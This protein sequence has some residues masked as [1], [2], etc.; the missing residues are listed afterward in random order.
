[1]AT[2]KGSDIIQDEHLANAIKQAQELKKAYDE[3][4]ASVVKANKDLSAQV[5]GNRGGSAKQ[6]QELNTALQES[7]KIKNAATKVDNDRIRLE[8]QLI[9]LQSEEIKQNE[10]LKVKIAEQRKENKLLAKETAGL[11]NAYTKLVSDTDKAQANFKKLAAQFGVNSSQ[12]KKAKADFERLDNEL[13]EINGSARDGRRD[14]GRY[15]IALQGA[16]GGAKKLLGALGVVGGVQLFSRVIKDAFNVV[17][18][19]DQSQANLA[20]VLGV[21]RESMGSLTEQAKALG[22]TTK[23]TASNVAEL[24]LEFAKLGFVQS[25][26]EGMTES[27]LQLAAAAGTDLG[28]AAAITGAT[29]RGFGLETSETQR[30][31]DVM[32]KSFSSSSLDITKFASAMSAVAPVANAAG[33]NIERTTALLGTLTDRGIDAS[34]AGT[35]LRNMFLSSTAA[36]ISF[37][38]ALAKVR[39]ASDKT[40]ESLKLFGKKGATLGVILA[41]NGDSVDSLEEKLN[42]AGGA[43]G[44]MADKQI[45]TL[46]GALDILRSSWEGAI[47]EMNEASGASDGLKDLILILAESIP[48]LVRGVSGLAGN[49]ASLIK[50]IVTLKST[51]EGAFDSQQS[52]ANAVADTVDSLLAEVPFISELTDLL[53]DNK[54]AL[55]PLT[56]EQKRNNYVKEQSLRVGREILQQNKEEISDVSVLIDAL[57][58]ENTTRQE[59]DEIITKLQQDYPELL[60]N[61]DLETAS[62]EALIQVKKDLI[63]QILEQA[64]AQK[65]AETEAALAGV[66]LDKELQKIG[67]NANGVKE[68]NRQIGELSI[69]FG[70]IDEATEKVRENLKDTVD[71]IDLSS[72]FR[73]ENDEIRALQEELKQLNV[74]LNST[75]DVDDRAIISKR[76]AK[77]TKQLEDATGLRTKMLDDALDKEA[78]RNN[79]SVK[80]FSDAEKKKTAALKKEINDRAELEEKLSFEARQQRRKDEEDQQK[81]NA[82][83]LIQN[84]KDLADKIK[85]QNEQQEKDDKARLDAIRKREEDNF[86]E[87]QKSANETMKLIQNF[88]DSR[89]NEIDRLIE[90]QRGEIDASQN[91]INRLQNLA[92]QGNNDAAESLKA[93][94]IQQ[95]KAKQE[96]E[97]LEKK[98]RNLLLTVA[99]LNQANAFFQKGDLDGFQKAIGS[100]KSFIN[101]LPTFYEGTE[102]TVADAL[103]KPHL[104][105]SKDAY[106]A[107]VDGKE[108]ILTGDKMDALRNV[109]LRTTDQITNAAM[110]AQTYGMSMNAM[111]PPV[112]KKADIAK[113]IGQEINKAIKDKFVNNYFDF[114][115]MVH[116]IQQ[117]NTTTNNDYSKKNL[118]A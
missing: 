9:A 102:T 32:A 38:E 78:Q 63:G 17:K 22:A 15:G 8:Q 68:L 81:E 56:E 46:G 95:A 6:I 75:T 47:L 101:S 118:Q 5:K 77:I 99:M 31:V 45:D 42:N 57:M 88:A 91:E 109:G 65:K 37:D 89:V 3:L 61:I 35:G 33:V 104:N 24:Q 2:I 69:G 41:E 111:R 18:E 27:T 29:M 80:N 23:F 108:G 79:E 115:T 66:I 58:D 12:A 10:I 94:K 114:E 83:I 93:E 59:K 106:L 97:N 64:I 1:M 112:T 25:E 113:T 98:K 36:G 117:G 4:D 100:G 16:A 34:S 7:T 71:N 90:K 96:I 11:T 87:L 70:L 86:K 110:K 107:R 43:A 103:G 73:A 50:K 85:L 13:R 92:S 21:T 51:W 52:F 74:E 14:V 72:A 39:N 40:G 28:N 82:E 49:L 44:E 20:S 67:S 19:F 26:I 54:N 76:I 60:K 84:A 105:T 53:R 116:K 30:V 55:I 48:Y 62:T